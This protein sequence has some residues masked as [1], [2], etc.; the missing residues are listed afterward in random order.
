MPDNSAASEI[1]QLYLYSS[2]WSLLGSYRLQL[3]ASLT[4]PRHVRKTVIGIPT[5]FRIVL[6]FFYVPQKYV[7][8]ILLSPWPG[9]LFRVDRAPKSSNIENGKGR[10]DKCGQKTYDVIVAD[11]L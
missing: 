6:R 3:V 1:H 5:L 11:I 7:D 10:D 8:V 9:L 4:H 2:N